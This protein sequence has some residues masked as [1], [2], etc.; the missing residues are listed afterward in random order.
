MLLPSSL[1]TSEIRNLASKILTTVLG[2]S[3]SEGLDKYQLGLTEICFGADV[4]A[5]LENLRTTCLNHHATVI[6]KNLKGKYY[7]SKYLEQERL[8]QERLEQERLEQERLEQERLEQERLGQE[9]L[10]LEKR[11]QEK[12]EQ[13]RLKQEEL[14]ERFAQK[15]REQERL[16]QA[17]Q[18]Q[19][20]RDQDQQEQEKRKL[21]GR[22]EERQRQGMREQGRWEQEKTIESEGNLEP[23]R[24]R[25]TPTAPNL[26]SG[27][28]P[29][30]AET[31]RAR[32]RNRQVRT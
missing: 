18:E 31:T 4:L 12:R 9:R 30:A 23:A 20:K 5:I 22:E 29:K 27:R 24:M 11:D 19:E 28:E 2:A 25:P 21:D 1:R 17:K 26:Q 10:E 13:E 3:K 8:E 7:R 32:P 14:Q 15:L 16:E 6:Q